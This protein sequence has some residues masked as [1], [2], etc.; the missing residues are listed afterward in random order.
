MAK[1]DEAVKILSTMISKVLNRTS[2]AALE[3]EEYVIIIGDQKFTIKKKEI[4]NYFRLPFEEDEVALMY[5]KRLVMRYIDNE[6]K[7][8]R[9]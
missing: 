9:E 7:R 8:I 2:L 5:I 1:S 6:W 4:D 3:E